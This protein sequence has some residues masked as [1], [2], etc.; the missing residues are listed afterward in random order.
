[1]QKKKKKKKKKKQKKKQKKKKKKK[2]KRND[3]TRL[4]C[5]SETK[6]NQQ[7][8]ASDTVEII[9]SNAIFNLAINNSNASSLFEGPGNVELGIGVLSS[10]PATAYSRAE[11]NLVTANHKV[12]WGFAHAAPL[13]CCT[14]VQRERRKEKMDAE[15][16]RK[17]KDRERKEKERR[18]RERVAEGESRYSRCKKR[19]CRQKRKSATKKPVF[20]SWARSGRR[21][22]GPQPPSENNLHAEAE[23][24][25]EAEAASAT[26]TYS[27]IFFVVYR[28]NRLENALGP[29]R[30]KDAGALAR[31][32]QPGGVP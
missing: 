6:V 28:F 14:S 24:E 15:K 3:V 11:M 23:A 26:S 16:E 20:S 32:K 31:R 30:K 21:T 22:Y 9:D 25:A 17:D 8:E 29:G 1:M 7:N 4:P 5:L 13:S 18:E 10:R 2:K 12:P 27:I 19:G